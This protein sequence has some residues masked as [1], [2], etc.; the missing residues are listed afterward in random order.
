MW[1]EHGSDIGQHGS[2]GRTPNLMCIRFVFF[3]VTPLWY[4][5]MYSE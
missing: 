2:G 3:T 1:R 4:W 5:R